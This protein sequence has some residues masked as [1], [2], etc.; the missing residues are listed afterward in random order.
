MQLQPRIRAAL[1][2]LV[3]LGMT[4]VFSSTT[5]ADGFKLWCKK[6]EP[7]NPVFYSPFYGYYR[8]CWR[9]FPD[10]QPPCCNAGEANAAE[11][12]AAP[13]KSTEVPAPAKTEKTPEKL[14]DLKPMPPVKK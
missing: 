14:P 5:Q 3:V 4:A 6:G 13:A 7:I 11:P 2:T 9:Q 1:G 10:T 8:T 12:I